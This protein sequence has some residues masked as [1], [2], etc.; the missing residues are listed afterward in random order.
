VLVL[1][2][3]AAGFIGSRLA[4]RLLADGH[5]VVGLDVLRPY[6]DV[7]Q[8]R[9]NLARLETNDRFRFEVADLTTDDLK[10]HLRD[11]EVVFH[12][13]AQPGVR[14]S[15]DEFSIYLH[16][17]VEATQRLLTA[18][19]DSPSLRRLVYASSS[20]VYGNAAVLPVTEQTLPVPLSPYGVTKLA[21]EHLATLYAQNFGVP[22]VSLRYF[23]VYGPGQRPDMAI[24]RMI[25][26]GL[27][28]EPF[29]LFGDG[30]QV[31]DFTYVDDVVAA[32]V[33]AA[34][35]ALQPGLALNVSGGGAVTVTDLLAL[36]GEAV[37]RA[38]PVSRQPEQAGDVTT[39]SGSTAQITS[40]TGWMPRVRLAAGLNEQVEWQRRMY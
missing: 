19:V 23:T 33:V 15:W 11:V 29:P 24:H 5:D 38:V 28:E 13:A 10:S 35:A 30:S 20:S 34:T 39:T 31:R 12:E 21:A 27:L 7:A 16:D 3:G 18:C 6:Y 25:R 4:A 17:N 14:R 26:A 40:L 9:R 22:T 36:V 37:G 2:T 8:K 1:V 32:N